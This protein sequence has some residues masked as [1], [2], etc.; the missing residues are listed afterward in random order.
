MED[1]R[2]GSSAISG[3]PPIRKFPCVFI[4]LVD[5]TVDWWWCLY[6][7]VLLTTCCHFLIG[8]VPL[9][10]RQFLFAPYQGR[11]LV[12]RFPRC[13][14]VFWAW[15]DVTQRLKVCFGSWVGLAPYLF[16]SPSPLFF[17]CDNTGKNY[18]L[19]RWCELSLEFPRYFTPQVG[20]SFVRKV[21]WMRVTKKL[22]FGREPLLRRV[23]GNLP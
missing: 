23:V 19:I 22:S 1:R 18:G 12:L 4:S 9:S 17:S 15:G 2:C 6:Y 11:S 10:V 21:L 20:S 14:G 16:K 8:W 3:V 7:V 13:Q 5:K